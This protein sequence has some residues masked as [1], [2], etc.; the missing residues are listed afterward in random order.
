M[1]LRRT[2]GARTLDEELERL[3]A[4]YRAACAERRVLETA[5]SSEAARPWTPSE[6]SGPTR[7][8]EYVV[9]AA[10]RREQLL[11]LAL[12]ACRAE[13]SSQRATAGSA[14]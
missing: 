2:R 7:R 5:R 6:D 3:E 8:T 13:R 14:Y 9:A 4:A 1:R 10:R 12:L 11:R